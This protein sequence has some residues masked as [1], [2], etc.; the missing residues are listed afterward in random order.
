MREATP[1][2]L[3]DSQRSQLQAW[4]RGR[5]APYRVMLRSWIVLLAAS[6]KSNREISRI[7]HT[8]PITV[9]RWRSRFALFGTEGIRKEAPHS[10]SPDPVPERVARRIVDK[11]LQELPR[12]GHRWTTRSLGREVGVSHTTV[13]RIWRGQGLRPGRPRR[14][15]LLVSPRF[16]P[17]LL[18]L[19]GVYINPPHRAVA[20][21]FESGRTSFEN[22]G[23]Y[24]R[25]PRTPRARSTSPWILELI[26]ALDSLEQHELF[27]R[28]KRFL[29]PE[30]L[31]F[32]RSVYE[33][34]D[35]K[36]KIVVFMESGTP[37]ISSSLTRWLRRHPRI[38]VEISPGTAAWEQ[39]LIRTVREGT[40]S[41]Q[42]LGPPPSL[43]GFI[44]A[45]ERWRRTEDGRHVPFA[46][47]ARSSTYFR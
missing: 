31:S 33:Q 22:T 2:V 13:Q 6:G 8:N 25:N 10:G 34:N 19:G 38:S 17:A 4:C 23:S 12:E 44:A 3:S 20:L 36:E 35:E 40:S 26:G 1:V 47:I 27:H 43:P 45:V 14:I 39:K 37:A 30:L 24:V 28:S 15:R 16:T 42:A 9:A 41:G 7:L 32:F 5:L 29:N 18:N 46:W 11:T 21:T